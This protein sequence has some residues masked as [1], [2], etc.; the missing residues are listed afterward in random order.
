[1]DKQQQIEELKKEIEIL[2]QQLADKKALL[3]GLK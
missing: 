3:N 1:M 2:K